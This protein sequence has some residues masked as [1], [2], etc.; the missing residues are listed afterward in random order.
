MRDWFDALPVRRKLMLMNYSAFA[1]TAIIFMLIIGLSGGNLWVG[2]AAAVVLAIAIQP[3]VIFLDS[4]IRSSFSD[5]SDAAYRISKG[6]FTQK[7]D[8]A[9]AGSL[10]ELGHS[11]NSMIDKLRDILTETTS[12][13]RH[14]SDASHTIFESNSEIKKVMEQVAASAMELAKGSQEISSSVTDMSN[15]V[16]EIDV[17][18][19][20]YAVST[21]EMNKRSETTLAWVEKGRQALDSQAD[22]MQKN[23]AATGKMSETIRDLTQKAQ[24]ISS[25]TKS[26]SEIAD[27]TNLLSLNA[28]IE[29]ARAGEHGRGFA[30]VAQEVRN[31]AEQS[32]SSTKQVFS[33]VKDITE[34]IRQTTETM[35]INEEVVKLQTERIHETEQVFVEIVNSIQFISEQISLFVRESDAML[36]SIRH[37]SSAI[38]NISAITQQSAAGTEQVSVSMNEQIVSVQAVVDETERMR[39]MANQL[40]RTIQIFKIK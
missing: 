19:A 6:D 32:M 10:G 40:Q 29:A 36:D 14:V 4:T 11:F 23:I 22:G 38:H 31:L 20:N 28:S 27:Q 34:G 12:I 2:L 8:M 17:L 16:S 9:S 15:S 5:M 33:L 24:G 18:V 13:T 21:Q 1:G 35:K 3:V 30:V 7:I 37:I 39:T 25:I 26:I